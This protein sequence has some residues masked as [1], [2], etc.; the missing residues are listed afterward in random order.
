MKNINYIFI[1]LLIKFEEIMAIKKVNLIVLLVILIVSI[2]LISGSIYFYGPDKFIEEKAEEIIKE[3][4]G[5]DIDLTPST[6]EV[7]KN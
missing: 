4:T 1:K 3:H 2:I 5:M 7:K 6:P